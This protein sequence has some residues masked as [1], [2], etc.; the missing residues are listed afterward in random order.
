MFDW[1]SIERDAILLAFL[2]PEGDQEAAALGIVFGQRGNHLHVGIAVLQVVAANQIAVGLDAVRIVDV[3][4]AEEAQDIGFAGL[5][6]VAQAIRRNRAVADELDGLDAGL[7]AFGDLE[8]EI[9]A[10]VGLFDDLR[11]DRD[12]V[13]SLTAIDF[14]DAL[15]IRLHR[16]AGTGCRAASTA[17]RSRAARP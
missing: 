8:D 7:A 1:M 17:P 15:R 14:R 2:D 13:T 16:S 4:G 5:D 9:D 12:V 11:N 3:G 6:D 10:V